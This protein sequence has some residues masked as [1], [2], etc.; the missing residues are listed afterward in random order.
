MA[1]LKMI[2]PARERLDGAADVQKA[3]GSMDKSGADRLSR[4]FLCS[5]LP[6]YRITKKFRE[7]IT[8]LYGAIFYA[9]L[10][11]I[12]EPPLP[13]TVGNVCSSTAFPFGRLHALRIQVVINCLFKPT[14]CSF[15]VNYITAN[16]HT[17][18]LGAIKLNIISGGH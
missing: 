4:A 10:F 3:C 18:G 9:Q 14:F 5:F 13:A 8:F 1:Y 12:Q 11:I 17:L 15:S 16:L 7:C 2:F 6:C